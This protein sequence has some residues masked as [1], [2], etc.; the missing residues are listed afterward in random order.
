MNA[1]PGDVLAEVLRHV[2]QPGRVACMLACKAL[3]CAARIPAVWHNGITLKQLDRTAVSFVLAQSCPVVTIESVRPDDVAWFLD[4]LAND[5]GDCVLKD[6][7]VRL[8]RLQRV[9]AGLTEAMCRHR[10]LER[11]CLDIER[12]DNTSEVFFAPETPLPKLHTLAV[13]EQTHGET[14]TRQLVVWFAGMHANLPA[15]TTVDLHVGMSDIMVSVDTMPSLRHL[16]YVC[17]EDSGG[18]TYE[19]VNLVGATLD[20]LEL[21]VGVHTDFRRLSDHL[22]QAHVRKLVLHVNDEFLDLMLPLGPDLVDLVLSMRVETTEVE[23]DFR[24]LPSWQP[25]LASLTVIPPSHLPIA[26]CEYTV[27]FRNC[28]TLSDWV[29]FMGKCAIVTPPCTRMHALPH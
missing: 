21:E 6:L 28:D 2:D 10:A 7:S 9:P 24:T 15:L 1:L 17:D 5:G 13:R 22:H 26:D 16:V 14:F 11:L 23:F 3:S 25:N 12:L 29:A 18:E 19:D 4:S 27:S 8:G 20:V